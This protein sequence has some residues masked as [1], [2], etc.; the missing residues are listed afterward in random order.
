MAMY[1]YQV[2]DREGGGAFSIHHTLNSDHV[3]TGGV[4]FHHILNTDRDTETKSKNWGGS[5][6]FWAWGFYGRIMLGRGRLW[7]VQGL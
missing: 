3:Q 4:I 7:S 6:E 1:R 5:R 2:T